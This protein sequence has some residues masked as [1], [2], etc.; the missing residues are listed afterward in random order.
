MLSSYCCLIYHRTLPA[1]VR[2]DY[3]DPVAG[4][5]IEHVLP[6]VKWDKSPRPDPAK[7]EH[8][9]DVL[10]RVCSSFAPS[11]Y[12]FLPKGT[13]SRGKM[14]LGREAN[15]SPPPSTEVKNGWSYTST[16]LTSLWCGT[17]LSPGTILHLPS[18]Q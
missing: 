4:P 15:H 10:K 9:D 13:I 11:F 3:S 5:Y 7:Y 1:E 6:A 8:P 2:R 16:P 18:V 12:S 17:S 14:R